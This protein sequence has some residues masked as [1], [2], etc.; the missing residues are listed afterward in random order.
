[1]VKK[2]VVLVIMI[3]LAIP[4]FG[5]GPP[6]APFREPRTGMVFPAKLGPL[7]FSGSKKYDQP[8]LG[9]SVGYHGGALI[10]ADIFI[11]DL[12]QKNLGTGL[13]SPAVTAQFQQAKGDIFAL[14]KRGNYQS[15]TVLSEQPTAFST[16]GG[17][18]AIL[19]A[20]FKYSQTAGPGVAFTG[21][22]ISHLLL[23]AYKGLFVKVRFTYPETDKAQGDQA[24]SQF[25]A[26]L[27]KL[28]K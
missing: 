15:V 24:L 18:L 1:M 13:G 21:P 20:G 6:S 22:R 14:E 10:K 2:L 4:A 3:V 23:T 9:V 16:P 28:L 25:L 17:K 26:A 11:Y 19:A 12:G 27:G 7:E 5:Q 8:E